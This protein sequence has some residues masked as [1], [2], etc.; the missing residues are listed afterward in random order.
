VESNQYQN[1]EQ[2]IKEVLSIYFSGDEEELENWLNTTDKVE[3]KK[4]MDAIKEV[5]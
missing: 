5:R 4:L 1:Y 3:M 2:E